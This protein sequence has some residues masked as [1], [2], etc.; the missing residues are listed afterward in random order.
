[1]AGS[2]RPPPPLPMPFG[3][4]NRV[5]NADTLKAGLDA[6]VERTRA[7]AN[8]V[9]QASVNGGDGFALPP[10]PAMPAPGEIATAPVVDLEGE[11]VSLADEQLH[12]ESAAK[13]LQKTYEKIRLSIRE[14]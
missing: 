2:G 5:S 9:A 1:M 13:L 14:R 12:F 6:S 10:T 7:I 4:V 11:M 3:F 8:R